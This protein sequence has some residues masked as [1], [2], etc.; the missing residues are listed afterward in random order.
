MAFVYEDFIAAFPEFS[1]IPESA[2]K[3]RGN[4]ADRLI[5]PTNWGDFRTDAVFLFTA[6][7]LAIEYNITA[8]LKEFGKSTGVL[9]S[10]MVTSMS[11]S[12]ASLSQS[13]AT[14]A[15]VTSD[16]PLYADLG[17]TIYGLRYLELMEMTMAYGYVVISPNTY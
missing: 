5:H 8:A 10:G 12:N 15:L 9:N 11:A 13:F 7:C 16:N 6:H 4:F 17:R 3:Y 14:N 1:Q 2:V